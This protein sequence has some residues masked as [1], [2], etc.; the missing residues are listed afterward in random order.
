MAYQTFRKRAKTTR[1]TAEHKPY[2]SI[3]SFAEGDMPPKLVNNP[4]LHIQHGKRGTG[5]SAQVRAQMA[6]QR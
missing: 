6:Q 5:K 1:R 3:A 2:L 4:K